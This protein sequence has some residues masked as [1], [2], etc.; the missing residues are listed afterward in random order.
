[1]TCFSN[2]EIGTIFPQVLHSIVSV[3]FSDTFHHFWLCGWQRHWHLSSLHKSCLFIKHLNPKLESSVS[4]QNV[5]DD[6]VF[7]VC[8]WLLLCFPCADINGVLVTR[9]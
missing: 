3:S 9:I 1:M 6:F 4:V 8:V 2:S 7:T 5:L